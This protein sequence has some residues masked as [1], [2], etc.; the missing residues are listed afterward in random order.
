MDS[1]SKTGLRRRLASTALAMVLTVTGTLASLVSASPAQALDPPYF[2]GWTMLVNTKYKGYNDYWWCLSTNAQTSNSGDGT[3]FVY[4][5]VCNSNTPGQWWYFDPT[6]SNDFYRQYVTNFVDWNGLSW[7][8]SANNTRPAGGDLGTYG[9]FTVPS[10]NIIYH[11]WL[12]Y[13]NSQYNQYRVHNATTSRDL[14]ASVYNP[15][16]PGT[17]RVYTT[18]ASTDPS[19]Y[20]QPYNLG[21]APPY[22]YCPSTA[23]YCGQFS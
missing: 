8:L 21:Y 14:S 23:P 16:I 9:A 4:L 18:A 17:M 13:A 20:W 12:T 11:S 6:D 10:D 5:A 7:D 22:A 19:H 3:H 2:V 15:E 1:G